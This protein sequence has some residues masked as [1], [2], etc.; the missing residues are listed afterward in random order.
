LEGI[1]WKKY[2]AYIAKI[3][4]NAMKKILERIVK[5]IALI[6]LNNH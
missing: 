2:I 3:I 5:V 6:L 4:I 1:K